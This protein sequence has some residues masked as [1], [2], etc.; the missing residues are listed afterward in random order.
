[1]KRS[2]YVFLTMI[3]IIGVMSACSSSNNESSANKIDNN[4]DTVIEIN[5]EGFPIDDEALTMTM[6]GPKAQT[7]EWK[8]MPLFRDYA[9]KTNI[10]FEFNTAPSTNSGTI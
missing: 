3:I 4:E 5:K 2:I 7:E 9:E 8:N 10:K 6:M 1:M